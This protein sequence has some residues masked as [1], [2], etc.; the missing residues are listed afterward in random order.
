MNFMASCFFP[1]KKVN[2]SVLEEVSV[3]STNKIAPL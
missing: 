1:I 2:A 3:N